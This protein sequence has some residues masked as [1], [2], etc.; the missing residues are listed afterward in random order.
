MG[1]G[2]KYVR[3]QESARG[4]RRRKPEKAR[5]RKMKGADEAAEAEGEA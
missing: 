4:P 5:G 1:E 2:N 3:S